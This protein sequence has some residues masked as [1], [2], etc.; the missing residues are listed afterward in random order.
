M[1]CPIR[2]FGQADAYLV[3][4]H[5][6]TRTAVS[7]FLHCGFPGRVSAAKLR[8]QK[9]SLC[10]SIIYVF[11]SRTIRQIPVKIRRI[12]CATSKQTSLTR[13]K[14]FGFNCLVCVT[15]SVLIRI[16]L[17]ECVT[18]VCTRTLNIVMFCF[19]PSA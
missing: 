1:W 9:H 15:T 8:Y 11:K 5:Y 18:E 13:L 2:F 16:C 19:T 4:H 17:L 3:G 10:R 7:V 14:S 12:R 6:L